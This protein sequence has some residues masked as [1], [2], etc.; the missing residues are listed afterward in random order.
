[1]MNANSHVGTLRYPLIMY[2]GGAHKHFFDRDARPTT[3]FNY[4]EK[5][6]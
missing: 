6:E 1:M 5:I 4:P 3:N 2:P